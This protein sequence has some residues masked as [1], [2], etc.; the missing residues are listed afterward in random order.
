MTGDAIQGNLMSVTQPQNPPDSDC[1]LVVAS[2]LEWD[3]GSTRYQRRG[4]GRT[5]TCQ[6]ENSLG[7][8]TQDITIDVSISTHIVV[9][10]RFNVT[11]A[12]TV[13]KEYGLTIAT[14]YLVNSLYNTVSDQHHRVIYSRYSF[15]KAFWVCDLA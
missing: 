2:R 7:T 1:F 6:G 10:E 12:Y 14:V 11:T 3:S 15:Q 9:H 13:Y 8:D 4:A 5:V